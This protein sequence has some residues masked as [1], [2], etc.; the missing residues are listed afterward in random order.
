MP[1][2]SLYGSLDSPGW[3]CVPITAAVSGIFT[4][5][6]RHHVRDGMLREGHDVEGQEGTSAQLNGYVEVSFMVSETGMETN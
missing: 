3:L 2:S 1:H 6:W 4:G 5:R